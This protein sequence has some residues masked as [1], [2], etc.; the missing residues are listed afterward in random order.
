MRNIWVIIL[1][2]SIG[3]SQ[4]LKLVD[5]LKNIGQFSK[6]IILLESENKEQHYY[7][8]AKLYEE[9]GDVKKANLYY[10]KKISIDSTN[11]T[12]KF[13]YGVFLMNTHNYKKA[14]EIFASISPKSEVVE[15]Y[16]GWTYEKRKLNDMALK[17]Y[18]AAS[19][20]D[21]LYF[22]SNFRQAFLLTERKMYSEALVI[23][24]RFLENDNENIEMLKLRGQIYLK[25]KDFEKS[26]HDFEVL[27]SLGIEEDF[28]LEL[29]AKNYYEL[30]RFKEALELYNLLIEKNREESAMYL[31]ERAKCYG[32]MNNLSAAEKDMLESID[33]RK[34]KFENEFFY[35]GY[36]YQKNKL[37]QKALFYYQ[38]VI[39]E[40]KSNEE[41]SYQVVAIKDYMGNS[42]EKTIKD[43]E[44]FLSNFPNSDLKRKEIITRRIKQLKE[45]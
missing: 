22:K 6:A 7:E 32:Q 20:K 1:M 14:Q 38:K 36:F 13:K 16:L 21:P 26:K 4:N 8:L 2:V 11:I 44:T 28:I 24:N 9:R 23:C 18:S 33:K 35:L 27:L 17:W 39:N 25:Q 40:N 30:R 34:V 45:E 12:V 29:L 37:F 31:Y 3:Y 41:A 15:Y 5:S 10:E 43:Y 42:I 19:T